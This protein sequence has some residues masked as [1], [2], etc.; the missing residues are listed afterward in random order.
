MGPIDPET[1]LKL[2]PELISGESL[3]WAGQPNPRVLFH[4][5]DWTAIPFSV[6]WAGFSIFWEASALGYWGHPTHSA[7]AFFVL[8]GVPFVLLGQYLLWGRF[9]Y[10]AWIKRRTYYA[11]TDRRVMVLQEG[12]KRKTNFTYIDAIPT[13]ER[14][15]GQTGTI[16]FGARYPVVAGRGQRGRRLSR[17]DVGDVPVFADIDD[18]DSVYRTVVDLRQRAGRAESAFAR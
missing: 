5:D 6:M 1:A 18:K 12:F 7:P 3:L 16:W 10:D 9:F 17:F 4:S 11:V 2:Q 8:W 15:G 13:I 14:D